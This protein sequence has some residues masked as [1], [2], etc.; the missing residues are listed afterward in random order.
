MLVGVIDTGIDAS[1]PDIAPNFDAALSRNFTVDIPRSTGPARSSRTAPA[2]TRPTSTRTATARTWPAHRGGAERVGDRRR[3]PG[4]AAGEP[5]GRPGLRLFFLK[6][7]V[8]AITYAADH[9]VDVVNLSFFVDPWLFNCPDNPADSPAE[10]LEQR[11]IVA[12]VQAA[13]DHARQPGVTAVAALGNEHTDLGAPTFDAT[14][15]DFPPVAATAAAR[16]QHLPRS[17]R[18]SSTP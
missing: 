3:R 13:I 17:C 15:P 2:R 7:T 8:D 11:T 18:P 5:A 9:G 14:S 16:R 4:G 1:H 10:Q 6:P 12:A